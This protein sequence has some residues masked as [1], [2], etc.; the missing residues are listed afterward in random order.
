MSLESFRTAASFPVPPEVVYAAWLDA[1]KHAKMTGA[2]ATCDARVGGRFTAWDGYIEGTILEL[3]PG[4][5]IVQ[6]WRT[7]EFPAEANDSRVE[8]HLREADGGTQLVLAHSEIPKGRGRTTRAAG[9]STTF[10]R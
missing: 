7:S 4:A 2:P 1:A 5:R 8:L 9:S 6:A 10:R 3:E